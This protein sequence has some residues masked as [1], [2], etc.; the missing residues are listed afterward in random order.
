M[1]ADSKGWGARNYSMAEGIQ[2]SV[3]SR[4]CEAPLTS[5]SDL[6]LHIIFY[7]NGKGWR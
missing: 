7:E 3:T 2:V 4:I 6:S 5:A 1:S